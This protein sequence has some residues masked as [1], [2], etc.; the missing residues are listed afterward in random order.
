M[1]QQTKQKTTTTTTWRHFQSTEHPEFRI[2]YSLWLFFIKTIK[3]CNNVMTFFIEGNTCSLEKTDDP[4]VV[5]ELS[6]KHDPY[7]LPKIVFLY[8]CLIILIPVFPWAVPKTEHTADTLRS[9]DGKL[10]Q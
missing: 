8:Q 1:Q 7:K 3:L 10:S 4:A 2:W 6:S 5:L 9:E